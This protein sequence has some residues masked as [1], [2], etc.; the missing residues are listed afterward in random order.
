MF[1]LFV[2]REAV[3]RRTRES[4]EPRLVRPVRNDAARPRRERVRATSAAALRSLANR[5]EPSRA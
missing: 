2:A 1:E 3:E 4:L 5:L